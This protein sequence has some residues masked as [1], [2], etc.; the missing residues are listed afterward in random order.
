M[1]N[2]LAYRTAKVESTKTMIDGVDAL[3]DI[4]PARLVGDTVYDTQNSERHNFDANN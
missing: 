1:W 3:F 4:N 2:P